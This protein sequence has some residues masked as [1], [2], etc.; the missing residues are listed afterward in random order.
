MVRAELGVRLDAL[1]ATVINVD[2]VPSAWSAFGPMAVW[3]ARLWFLLN[4]LGGTTV[5]DTLVHSEV[6]DPTTGYKQTNYADYWELFPNG[7]AADFRH[8]RDG[9]TSGRAPRRVHPECVRQR[10][11]LVYPIR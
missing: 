1:G 9:D 2:S 10:A 8:C 7:S 3:N 6:A 4:T 11:R 5:R